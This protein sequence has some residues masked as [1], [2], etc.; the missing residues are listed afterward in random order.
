MGIADVPYDKMMMQLDSDT[1]KY[2]DAGE[3]TLG[4]KVEAVCLCTVGISI[5]HLGQALLGLAL[6]RHMH[7]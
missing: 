3:Q 6:I 2:Q 1:G 5:G 7:A 4:F